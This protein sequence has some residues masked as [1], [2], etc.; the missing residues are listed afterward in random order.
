M[1]QRPLPLDI[2]LRRAA[3]NQLNTRAPVT[4]SFR[5]AEGTGWVISVKSGYVLCAVGQD[6]VSHIPLTS[7]FSKQI[8]QHAYNKKINC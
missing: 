1:I 7:L 4:A 5:V 8:L 3:A 6:L 2:A